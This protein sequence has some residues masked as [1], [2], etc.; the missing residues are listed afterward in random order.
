[1][2]CAT[3]GHFLGL[4]FSLSSS[5]PPVSTASRSMCFHLPVSL[6]KI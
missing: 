2:I 1:M 6:L 5:P 4:A 3:R